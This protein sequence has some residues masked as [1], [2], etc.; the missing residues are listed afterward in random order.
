MEHKNEW[1]AYKSM[2]VM[3]G[4]FWANPPPLVEA[5]R[6]V[7]HLDRSLEPNHKV[8]A[9]TIKLM[10]YL[11]TNLAVMVTILFRC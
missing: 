5:P 9:S 1:L 11:S 3:V 4:K 8:V 7:P 10:P 2:I 6:A